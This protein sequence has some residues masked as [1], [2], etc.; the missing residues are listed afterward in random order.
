M[1]TTEFSGGTRFRGDD[2][3]VLS[4]ALKG[5]R[6]VRVYE[7]LLAVSLVAQGQ[8][9]SAAA[10]LTQRHPRSVR[11]WVERFQQSH[12]VEALQDGRRSGRPRTARSITP[13]R[14]LRELQRQP[15]SLGYPSTVWTVHWLAWHLNQLYHCPISE[16]TLRRRMKQ[17]NLEWKRPRYVYVQKD[18]HRGH[19]KGRFAGSYATASPGLSS[20][21]RMKPFCAS[22]RHCVV[23]GPG[24][25]CRPGC[26]LRAA[27][28]S[29]CSMEP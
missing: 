24:G 7:R 22:F 9:L 12:R 21:P 1:R 27:T 15:L 3:K 4:A 13:A 19:K 16:R 25:V 10:H 5:A 28:P 8:S 20:S 14:I 11:R 29:A 2:L 26:P 18:A 23:P 6:S 17:L